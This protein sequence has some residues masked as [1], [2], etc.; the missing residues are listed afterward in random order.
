M[1]MIQ[2]KIFIGEWIEHIE[3]WFIEFN[4]TIKDYQWN[5]GV[6]E[7][8]SPPPFGIAPPLISVGTCESNNGSDEVSLS[9]YVEVSLGFQD[10]SSHRS[11][12]RTG[13]ISASM[14]ARYVD[15]NNS[16][17]IIGHSERR[18]FQNETDEVISEKLKSF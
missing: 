16:F 12:A 13:E 10:V 14:L 5:P 1:K 2:K 3:H 6:V 15:D 11:G 9:S 4:S 7:D 18:E 17:C 8:I